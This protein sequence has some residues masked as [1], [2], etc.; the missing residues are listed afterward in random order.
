MAMYVQDYDETAPSIWYDTSTGR[1]V[2]VFQTLQGYVK[3]WN[4]FLCPDR[5]DVDNDCSYATVPGFPLPNG[6]RCQ[7]YGY[8]WESI[9]E[10]GPHRCRAIN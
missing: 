6:S 5:T 7:A 1:K 10:A 2:D 9:P 4:I 3:S 8:N